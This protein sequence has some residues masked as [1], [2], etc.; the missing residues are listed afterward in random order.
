M[1]HGLITEPT[2]NILS[3]PLPLVSDRPR[4]KKEKHRNPDPETPAPHFTTHG[5]VFSQIT[6]RH[7]FP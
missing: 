4:P 2:W 3:I 5:K 7:R 1:S 6:T